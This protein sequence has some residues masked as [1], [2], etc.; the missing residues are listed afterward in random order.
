[1]SPSPHKTVSIIDSA[2][3]P[4]VVLQS[5]RPVCES[6]DWEL[7]QCYYA[8]KGNMAFLDDGVPYLV[9]NDG[10]LSERA[11]GLFFTSLEER[12]RS[13]V[14]PD[15]LWVLEFGAGSC[16]F[17]RLFEKAFSR[18][19]AQQG[20]DYA[21]RLW[22]IVADSSAAMLQDALKAGVLP[23]NGRMILAQ[24]D[25]IAQD[26]SNV[27][28]VPERFDAVFLN[29]VLCCLPASVLRESDGRLEQLCVQTE[30]SAEGVKEAENY[31][32]IE[33]VKAYASLTDQDH[34]DL[35][36]IFP[37]LTLRARYEPVQ[38]LP[39][40]A[41]AARVV[42]FSSVA[43]HNHGA[44]E[45][46]RTAFGKLNS[47]GLILLSDYPSQPKTDQTARPAS[48]HQRFAGS[49]AIGL[50]FRELDEHFSR[51]PGAAFLEP[52]VDGELLIVRLI[53]RDLGPDTAKWFRQHLSKP[54]LDKL[55]APLEEARLHVS[56]GA[57][58]AALKCFR[59]AIKLQPDNWSLLTEAAMFCEASLD[60]HQAAME[61]AQAAL[62]LNPINP[63]LWNILGDTLYSV[64]RID[65]AHRAY[66]RSLSLSPSDARA[67]VNMVHTFNRKGQ[68]REALRMITEA[69]LSDRDGKYRER[70]LQ[71]QKEILRAMNEHD[72][73]TR[74]RLADRTLFED[75]VGYATASDNN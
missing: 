43:I 68:P 51:E 25:A 21:G 72:K 46:L 2:V 50:N 59:E 55:Q 57:N 47:G 28:G 40:P 41:D 7:G 16:L 22:Y 20:R 75:G 13:Q 6:L 74:E 65:E 52:E 32:G 4:S 61:L 60:N 24:A 5:Y 23:D 30:L 31:G 11:A 71:R 10:L 1:M 56:K 35:V 73:R 33:Q 38:T 36:P 15:K 17:A 70:L 12:S 53:G 39:F 54:E 18:I 58:R 62:A 37:L 19:C 9:N 26:L 27:A 64:G 49:T 44:I 3:E 29:Y 63:G 67:K 48:L 66:E 42:T 8:N 14:L 69:L 45:C 34:A